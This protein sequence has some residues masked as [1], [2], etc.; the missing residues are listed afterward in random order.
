MTGLLAIFILL[1]I[2]QNSVC[3]G[4]LLS[5]R[6]LCDAYYAERASHKR[7]ILDISEFLGVVADGA[8]IK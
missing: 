3:L 4:E 7:S 6:T 8:I 1:H 5:M 2:R